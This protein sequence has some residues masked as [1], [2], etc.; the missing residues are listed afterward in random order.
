MSNLK[1][2]VIKEFGESVLECPDI[3]EDGWSLPLHKNRLE[4]TIKYVTKEKLDNVQ[5][6]LEL[7]SKINEQGG[8]YKRKD[9]VS[10]ALRLYRHDLRNICVILDFAGYNIKNRVHDEK[11]TKMVNID[12]INEF[13]SSLANFR[14]FSATMAYLASDGDTRFDVKIPYSN[15][16]YLL[17]RLTGK[18]AKVD[19]Q[20]VNE[21]MHSPDYIIISEFL[22]N[23]PQK[24]KILFKEEKGYLKLSVRDNGPGI[25]DEKGY[26]LSKEDI[27]KIFG[28]Y[29]TKS[30]SRGIGLQVAERLSELRGGYIEVITTTDGF[31]TLKFETRGKS[32]CEIP[33]R[34][35][36]GVT[37]TLHTPLIR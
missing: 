20:L 12:Y 4:E 10:L 27:P 28:S 22:Q 5:N 13:F 9:S 34:L 26:P 15:A 30:R 17:E 7:I 29:S 24:S 21:F 19:N 25:L 33:T 16:G 11:F 6:A 37:F 23:T 8:D 31:S 36:E 18:Q 2:L 1:D 32:C 14:L 35:R 3:F